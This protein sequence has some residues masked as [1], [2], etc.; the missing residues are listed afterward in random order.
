VDS[1]CRSVGGKNLPYIAVKCRKSLIVSV[2]FLNFGYAL[3][4]CTCWRLSAIKDCKLLVDWK[5]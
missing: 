5:I 1:S 4:I 2:L 3:R